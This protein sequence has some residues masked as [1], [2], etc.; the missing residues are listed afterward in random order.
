MRPLLHLV[1]LTHEFLSRALLVLMRSVHRT[2][3]RA[4]GIKV[5][6]DHRDT[7]TYEGIVV[8]DHVQIARGACLLAVEAGL[9]IGNKV[10]IAPNVTIVTGDHPIDLRGRFIYDIAVKSPGE[11]LPVVIEDDVWIG[12][13]A[14]ILKGVTVGRGAVVAAG[15]LVLDDVPPYAIVA[16]VPAKVRR[17]RGNSDQVVEHETSLYGRVVTTSLPPPDGAHP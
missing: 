2:R 4:V 3:F 17:Y 10:L 13:G 12:T 7:I 8:G 6:F 16:G 9:T 14:I 11:D 5:S 15:A 1:A